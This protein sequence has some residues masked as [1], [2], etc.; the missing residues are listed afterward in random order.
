MYVSSISNHG[1][2]LWDENG[3][4]LNSILSNKINISSSIFLVNNGDIYV[5]NGDITKRVDK[6]TWNTTE[7][8][9]IINVTR[10][11]RSLFVDI[12]NT[13]YCSQDQQHKV[14]KVF[15]NHNSYVPIIAAGNGSKG[16][17]AHT[18]DSPKGI[19]VDFNFNLY[20]AD[21]SNHR[22]QVFRPG[23]IN[24]TTVAG[25]GVPMGLVLNAP[26]GV[27]L[28]ADGYLFIADQLN[29]RI[30]RSGSDEYRCLVGCSKSES[31]PLYQLSTPMAISFDSHGN[32]FSIDGITNRILKFHLV[33][34]SCGK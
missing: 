3:N 23:R 22:I 10:M 7:G 13:L 2:L 9:P 21:Y 34:N 24:G 6:W 32:I 29:Y 18:L 16:T 8:I 33:T 4:E 31:L 30:I 12:N 20:V 5:D 25:R 1:I 26:N 27:I 15:L 17:E 28:D 11:C 14:V 19:F